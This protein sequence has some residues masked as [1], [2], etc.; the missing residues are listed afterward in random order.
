MGFHD[1]PWELVTK[2]FVDSVFHSV[3][4]T[5]FRGYVGQAVSART[6][7]ENRRLRPIALAVWRIRIRIAKIKDQYSE[8]LGSRYCMPSIIDFLA[9]YGA[10][11]SI[12]GLVRDVRRLSKK[13]EDGEEKGDQ[14]FV[15]FTIR[16]LKE[17][18]C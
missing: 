12:I 18:H 8:P 6:L 4:P 11:Q 3:V 15:C 1:D 13:I 5:L 16:F 7:V 2:Q 9:G 14:F 10:S 17:A